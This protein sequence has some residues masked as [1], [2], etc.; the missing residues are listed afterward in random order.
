MRY[1]WI[2]INTAFW[3]TFLG[4]FGVIILV[5]ESK[6]GKFLGKC[7]R[8][9]AKAILFFGGIKYSVKNLDNLNLSSSYVFAGNH[10][11]GFDILLGFAGL[12]FWIVSVA[13]IELRSVFILG[14]VMKMAGHI[15]IDRKNHDSAIASL[16]RASLS[17]KETPRSVLLYPEGTRTI[18]GVIKKFKPGGLLIAVKAGI[19]IVPIFYSGTYSILKRDSWKINNQKLELIIGEPISTKEYSFETRKELAL[20]VQTEV[21]KLSKGALL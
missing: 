1:I 7:A 8:A 13:K 20:K 5:F 19:P 18:D 2:L 3:T 12:P 17:L 6:K 21:F 10:A 15:F 16:K 9:W 4:L 11:S 14:F